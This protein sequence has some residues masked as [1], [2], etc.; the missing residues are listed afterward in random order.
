[1]VKQQTQSRDEALD[2][3]FAALSDATRRRLVHALAEGE[4]TVGELAEPFAMSL[5]AVSKHLKVLE[6]A[7]IVQRRVD[8]RKHYCT[9]APESLAG[10]LDWIAIYRNFWNLRLEALG[11]LIEVETGTKGKSK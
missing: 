9:L 6:A 11:A 3:V 5:V 8:G 4:K 10:A 2:R 1:M 7:G